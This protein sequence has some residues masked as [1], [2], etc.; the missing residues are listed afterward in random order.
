[1]SESQGP[2]RNRL[3]LI[4][5]L[6]AA[7]SQNACARFLLDDKQIDA[8]AKRPYPKTAPTASSASGID[9]L[10]I[11]ATQYRTHLTL[12]NRSAHAFHHVDLWLNQE[13]VTTVDDIPIGDSEGDG[14]PLG[15]FINKHSESYPVGG[16][17][18]PDRAFPIISVE[19]F[20]PATGKKYRLL[21]R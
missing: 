14:V 4:L 18:T 10:D 17:L 1:M 2:M 5:L 8:Y 19:L 12:N 21:A 6:A 15:V 13:Y 11:V 3:I 20:D 16:F 9:D 7:L